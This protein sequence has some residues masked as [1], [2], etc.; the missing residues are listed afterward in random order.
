MSGTL[1]QASEA[2]SGMNAVAFRAVLA[3]AE[4]L[5]LSWEERCA[6]LGIP[7]STYHRWVTQGVRQLDR[8]KRDR[9]AYLLAIYHYAGTAF[10]G[11]GG[12]KGWLLRPNSHPVFAGARPLDR[13]LCGGMEDL[14]AV[15][16]VARAA[17]AI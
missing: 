5:G 2:D 4:A 8:D 1:L 3:M 7:R 13:L 11:G 14:L 6:L 10:P 15:H 16:G 9:I 17:E 12:A